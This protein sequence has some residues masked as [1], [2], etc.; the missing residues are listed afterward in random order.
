HPTGSADDTS[1]IDQRAEATERFVTCKKE[2]F[3]LFAVTDIGLNSHSACTRCLA[4]AD[5][6][7]CCVGVTYIVDPEIRSLCSKKPCSR[8]AN[9]VTGSGHKD[10]RPFRLSAVRHYRFR[11]YITLSKISL[12][13]CALRSRGFD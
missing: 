10:N 2:L 6:L 12:Y 4:I 13:S 5:N 3:D 1:I 8:V 11:H 9:A 7:L